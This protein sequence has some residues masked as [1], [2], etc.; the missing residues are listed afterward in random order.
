MA[1]S[2][3]LHHFDNIRLEV[4]QLKQLNNKL[5][6]VVRSLFDLYKSTTQCAIYLPSEEGG[7]DFKKISD[8][9]YGSRI[10]F[11][12]KMLNHE[13]LDFQYVARESLKR[14]TTKRGVPN[15]DMANNFLGYEINDD[16]YLNSSSTF[17]GLSDWLE[18]S[19]YV[20][21]VEINVHF[22]PD[23]TR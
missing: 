16:R 6:D 1:L 11:L 20:R 12:L 10:S 3:I 8:V 9:Y 19:G 14:D 7:I 18:L 17:G 15:S 4:S 13:L 5:T 22:L 23:G 2:K 21:K